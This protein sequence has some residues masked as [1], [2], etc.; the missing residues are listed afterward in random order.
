M[1]NTLL[2]YLKCPPFEPLSSASL[3]DLTHKVVISVVLDSGQ[4]CS[5]LHALAVGEHLTLSRAGAT[6]Y[7]RPGFSGER[8]I[9]STTYLRDLPPANSTKFARAVHTA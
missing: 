1:F 7:V 5:E 9:F 2:N 8:S 3:E 6:L 4:R